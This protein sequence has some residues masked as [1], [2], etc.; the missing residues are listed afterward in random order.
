MVA[1]LID[2]HAVA[3]QV[4]EQCRVLTQAMQARGVTPGPA[5][6]IVSDNPASKVY[7]ANKIKACNEVGL[8][9]TVDAFDAATPDHVVEAEIHR[10][11]A[12]PSVP[13]GV[14]PMTVTMLVHNTVMAA[15]RAAQAAA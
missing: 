8:T 3:R 9:S 7:V 1:K 15:Q 4:R 14:G 13:G 11:N 10:L 5:V 2:G 12:D 6:L